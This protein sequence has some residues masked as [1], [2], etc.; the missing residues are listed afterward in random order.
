MK[1]SKNRVLM[2]R[3]VHSPRRRS[4]SRTGHPLLLH[5]PDMYL[6]RRVNKGVNTNPNHLTAYTKGRVYV[7]DKD[8]MHKNR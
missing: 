2:R 4:G 8:A 7:N 5:H 3:G 6:G 1:S